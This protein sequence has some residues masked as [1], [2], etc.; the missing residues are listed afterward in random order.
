MSKSIPKKDILEALE[1]MTYGEGIGL[2]ASGYAD[3]IEDV[4]EWVILQR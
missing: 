4:K 3:A 1:K 2:C